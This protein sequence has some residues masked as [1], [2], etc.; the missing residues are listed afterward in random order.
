[1]VHDIIVKY[2]LRKQPYNI[3]IRKQVKKL[4][5]YSYVNVVRC[6]M[7]ES[8][9]LILCKYVSLH[10]IYYIRGCCINEED[11][12]RYEHWRH[13]DEAYLYYQVQSFLELDLFVQYLKDA[14]IE[15]FKFCKLLN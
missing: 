2:T 5:K 14:I 1:M 3:V 9:I 4:V 13:V 6:T 7:I 11:Y 10:P 8:N 15:E 12:Y